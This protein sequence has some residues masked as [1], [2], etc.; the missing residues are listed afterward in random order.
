[1]TTPEFAKYDVERNWIIENH[2]VD[3]DI[4]VEYPP[5]IVYKGGDPQ[6][7]RAV[8]EIMKQIN[9]APK[10]LPQPPSVPPDKR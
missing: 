2:G 5:D 3:P 8:Q 4:E 1:M 9:A 10:S 7:D 6:I